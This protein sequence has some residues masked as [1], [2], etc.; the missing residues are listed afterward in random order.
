MGRERPGV[1]SSK[2]ARIALLK[3]RLAARRL[4]LKSGFLDRMI[5][6]EVEDELRE[7][8]CEGVR[9]RWLMP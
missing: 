3:A 1:H 8:G 9:V 7:R 2:C 4:A 6:R 5:L